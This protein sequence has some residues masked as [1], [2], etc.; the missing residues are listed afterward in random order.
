MLTQLENMCARLLIGKRRKP[1]QRLFRYGSA[2]KG[3]VRR[4]ARS[5]HIVFKAQW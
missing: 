4:R 3:Q 1:Q 2:L 5:T